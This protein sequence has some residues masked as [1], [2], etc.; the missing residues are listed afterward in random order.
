MSTG[1]VVANAG[2]HRILDA[3]S[4]GPKSTRELKN[5]VGAVNSLARFDS[6]Y[7]GRML[8]NGYVKRHDEGWV[9][10]PAGLGKLQ[11]LGPLS[12]RRYRDIA[13]PRSHIGKGELRLDKLYVTP[14][15][16]GAQDFLKYPS[17][18]ANELRYRDGR[19]EYIGAKD[20]D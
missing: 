20:G 15:R 1:K 10:T 11:Q 6:E 4:S 9:I 13:T 17:R 18:M 5:V 12:D 7:M 14:M 8:D 2:S 19:V 16:P 3:L